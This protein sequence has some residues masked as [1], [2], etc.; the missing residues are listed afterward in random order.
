LLTETGEGRFVLDYQV[1]HKQ[2][3]CTED[4]GEVVFPAVT[5]PAGSNKFWLEER[6]A[7]TFTDL[8]RASYT[9][10]LPAKSYGTGRFYIIASTNTPTG[11]NLPEQEA[12]LRIWNSFGKIIIKGP[13][14][15]G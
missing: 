15:S 13:V 12:G 2:L 4:G 9:V 11:V 6:T 8:S 14:T 3:Q 1:G 10:T 5:V 7:G